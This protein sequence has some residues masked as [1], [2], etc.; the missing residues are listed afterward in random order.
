MLSN[1]LKSKVV[2]KNM[3]LQV[4][5]ARQVQ[6]VRPAQRAQVQMRSCYLPIPRHRSLVPVKRRCC[7]TGM[8]CPMALLLAMRQTAR[9]LPLTNRVF[10]RLRFMVASRRR[11]VLAFRLTSAR[12][13]SSMVQ[14]CQELWHSIILQTQTMWQI[15]RLLCRLRFL[16]LR[17][18]YK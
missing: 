10:I 12:L 16:L 8:R 6:L 2:Y 14:V 3:Y 1:F 13:P 5:A 7:L 18:R 15:W 4:R 17:Q 9:P 11:K